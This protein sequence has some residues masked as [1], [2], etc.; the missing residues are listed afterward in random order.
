MYGLFISRSSNSDGRAKTIRRR[1]GTKQAQQL[2][3][4]PKPLS[5]V[6]SDR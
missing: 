5:A 1:E 6:A 3:T 2:F 4:K